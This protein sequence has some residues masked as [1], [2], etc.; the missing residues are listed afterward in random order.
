MAKYEWRD[1]HLIVHYPPLTYTCELQGDSVHVTRV[2]EQTGDKLP[3]I[4]LRPHELPGSIR[5]I[6][7]KKL[8]ENSH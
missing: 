1:N 7:E 4:Y 3:P 2:N 5:E 6:L 8:H